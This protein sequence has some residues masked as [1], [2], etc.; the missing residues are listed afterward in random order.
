MAGPIRNLLERRPLRNAVRSLLGLNPR[1][2]SSSM[3]TMQATDAAQ[4]AD[5]TAS[6]TRM[7]PRQNVD[8][9]PYQRKTTS[10]PPVAPSPE[11]RAV[12]M[13]RAQD[14][15]RRQQAQLQGEG[16]ATPQPQEPNGFS[17]A[18]PIGETDAPQQPMLL[19]EADRM[20]KLAAEARAREQA[21][22]AGP[23]MRDP[24]S[25]A[26]IIGEAQAKRH[27]EDAMRY[28]AA[29]AGYR[30]QWEGQG[31]T[32][33]LAKQ[34]LDSER[35]V[36]RINKPEDSLAVDAANLRQ[37]SQQVGIMPAAQLATDQFFAAAKQPVSTT[38]DTY[39]ARLQQ[40]LVMAS[41]YVL[42]GKVKDALAS[43]RNPFAPGEPI[44]VEL[45]GIAKSQ[46]PDDPAMRQRL[47]ATMVSAV[48]SQTREL[49]PSQ[50]R[51]LNAAL[52][53]LVEQEIERM[54]D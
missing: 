27:S 25:T 35:E 18:L 26:Y 1:Y 51:R 50:A 6:P 2:G 11:A 52:S 46:Y 10:Q 37:L 5:L 22:Y 12:S 43:R 7:A 28:T 39:K 14:G 34:R 8:N 13:A 53:K 32:D 42:S 15:E 23:L 19:R 16:I 49:Q 30:S 17:M 45:A 44:V 29:A 40:N 48:Q 9:T 41:T 54:E 24:K 36:A 47:I 33:A 31:H 4:G 20:D 38:D 21:V 3:D